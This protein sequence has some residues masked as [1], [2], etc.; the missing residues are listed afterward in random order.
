LCIFFNK[1]QVKIAITPVRIKAEELG[2]HRHLVIKGVDSGTWDKK[3]SS[4][5]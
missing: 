4:F 1:F 2:Q 5:A 3:S